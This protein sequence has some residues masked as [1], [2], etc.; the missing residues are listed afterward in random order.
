MVALRA[1]EKRLELIHLI[2]SSVPEVL[3]G[4]SVRVRQILVNLLT[5]AVKFTHEGEISVAVRAKHLDGAQYEYQFEVADTGIGIPKNRQDELFSPFYQTDASTTREFGGTGLGLSIS[6][7]LA[8]E[9]GGDLGVESVAGQGSTFRFTIRTEVGA[10]RADDEFR[11]YLPILRDKK[12]LLV[13]DND[14]S[15]NMLMRL[16]ESLDTVPR[17]TGNPAEAL[18]LLRSGKLF[19]LVL[20]GLTHFGQD[21]LVFA[22]R[23]RGFEEART[24]PLVLLRSV[25]QPPVYDLPARTSFLLKPVKRGRA[26]VAL[27]RGLDENLQHQPQES[28]TRIQVAEQSLSVLV[29]ED[30]AINQ[31]VM[32]RLLERL[33]H[34]A[35]V[36]GSGEVVVETLL[37][38]H[39]DVALL[40]VRMPGV[41][42]P[43]A[44]RA[45]VERFPH[46]SQRPHMIGMTASTAPDEK[47]KC[48]DSGMD[49]CLTKPITI[50]DLVRELSRATSRDRD[51]S[52]DEGPSEDE[53]RSSVRRQLASNNG[54]EPAF[55]AE[56]LTSFLRTAPTL[57]KSLEEQLGR[58]DLKGVRRSARTMK[59]SC[60]FIGL[61]RLAALSK[62]LEVSAAGNA[63]ESDLEP[64]VRTI[65]GEF[66]RIRPVLAEERKTLLRRAQMADT[67]N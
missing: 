25:T 64:F 49:T 11:Q 60:Q 37:H 45:V 10:M 20:V 33:G 14:A 59:S 41:T 43:E 15:R 8:R 58:K 13:D 62:A 67:T 31:K 47:Q 66:G 52:R 54:D 38:T 9:M 42:G 17:G 27:A 23:V 44:A 34:R 16:L 65:S 29:A 18:D 55:M 28:G 39:Y 53:I 36:V 61:M 50:E 2:D 40:D 12:I 24:T 30:D 5:N 4:D 7:L 6:R 26:I 57:L 63:G 21:P 48:I 3:I 19:D 22:R 56:L 51:T 46:P 32:L 35:D 1:S